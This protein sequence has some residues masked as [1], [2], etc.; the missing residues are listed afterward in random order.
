MKRTT[1]KKV[2]EERNLKVDSYNLLKI[3]FI[4]ILFFLFFR[5][6][7]PESFKNNSNSYFCCFSCIAKLENRYIR[8][9]VEHYLKLG[10]EKLIFGDDN[11]YNSEKISD[12]IQDYIKQGKVDIIDIRE[13]YL[14]QTEYFTLSYNKYKN[15]CK[16]IAYF[17]VDEH[18]EF[19]DKNMT[20]KDYLSKDIFNKC[21]AVK[22]NWLVYFGDDNIFYDRRPLSERFPIPNYNNRGMFTVKTIVRGNL[23]KPVWIDAGVHEPNRQLIGCDSVGNLVS[24]TGGEVRP[25]RLEICYLKHYGQKSVE[26]FAYKLK[27][28]L[29][30]GTKYNFNYMVEDYFRYNNFTKEKLYILESI[31]NTTFKQYHKND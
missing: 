19:T 13:K 18:L 7:G 3:V 30:H 12:T 10:F 25:P 6:K 26:E 16:W 17:D 21:E 4:V 1:R 8:E 31:L 22:I 14:P 5:I 9:T 15:K 24:Y 11:S 27:K 28:Q 2:Y 29:H 20:I 23:D